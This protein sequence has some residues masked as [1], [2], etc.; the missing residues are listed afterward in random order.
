M[1]SFMLNIINFYYVHGFSLNLMADRL[2]SFCHETKHG[3]GT[4]FAENVFLLARPCFLVFNFSSA[5]CKLKS[6]SQNLC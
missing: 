1:V 6:G 5:V 3:G 4:S 2:H